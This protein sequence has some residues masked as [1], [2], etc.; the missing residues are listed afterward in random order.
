MR[1]YALFQTG[2]A[3]SFLVL[4][5]VDAA[6]DFELERRPLGKRFDKGVDLCRRGCVYRGITVGELKPGQLLAA[7]EQRSEQRKRGSHRFD[8]EIAY[9][10]KDHTGDAE[11]RIIE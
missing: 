3:Q 9:D 10:L 5:G 11:L 2:L 1:F 7:A 6:G 8:D 4:L